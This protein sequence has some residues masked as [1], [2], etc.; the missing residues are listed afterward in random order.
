M[1]RWQQK[2]TDEPPSSRF[3]IQTISSDTNQRIYFPHDCRSPSSI[4]S[5]FSS[6]IRSFF[7]RKP[8]FFFISVAWLTPLFSSPSDDLCHAIKNGD[9]PK[10]KELVKSGLNLNLKSADGVAP[11]IVA[12]RYG[13]AEM[14][15]TLIEEKVD[16][17]EVDNIGREPLSISA[18]ASNSQAA[19]EFLKAGCNLNK[20]DFRGRTPIIYAVRTRNI[21]LVKLLISKGAKLNLE[22]KNG[23]TPWIEAVKMG[24]VEMM[25]LIAGTGYDIKKT[26]AIGRWNALHAASIAGKAEAVK[27]LL[28]RK[29]PVNEQTGN[30]G[31]TALHLAAFRGHLP[32][33][34]LL[35]AAGADSTI[36][37]EDRDSLLAEAVYSRNLELV[38]FLISKGVPVNARGNDGYYPLTRAVFTGNL[39]MV[40]TL[41]K[42]G[43]DVNVKDYRNQGSILAMASNFGFVEIANAIEDSGAE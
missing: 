37:T 6:F 28:Q 41:I 23:V 26:Y 18:S 11:I 43:A 19:S 25:D 20:T 24:D 33:V 29:F 22:D 3:V 5:T 7:M 38:Q 4:H 9:H 14:T 31:S 27:W 39:E 30:G 12:A 16:L 10:F 36:E 2:M 13:N 21:E 8:I 34:K 32:V 42:S 35:L 17:A 40:K 1:L 15:A